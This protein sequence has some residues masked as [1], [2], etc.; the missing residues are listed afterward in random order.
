L[1]V[2]KE[3]IAKLNYLGNRY[4]ARVM[5][6][7]SGWICERQEEKIDSERINRLFSLKTPDVYEKAYKL[8]KLLY[9]KTEYPGQQVTFDP[10]EL[11]KIFSKCWV[12]GESELLYLR[13]YLKKMGYIESANHISKITPD[14]FAYIENF[15]KNSESN[16]GFC[17]MWFDK[18][19]SS[20]WDEAIR[21]AIKMAGYD[22]MRIDKEPYNGGVVDEIIASIRRSKFVVADLTG[23]RDGVYFEAGFAKGLGI[24]VIF[25][26]RSDH[27]NTF[28]IHF[29]VQHFN[30]LL[31]EAH[32]CDKFKHNLSSRIES[33]LGR[34]NHVSD[35]L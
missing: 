8:L 22:A 34:G 16:I 1:L 14:G 10:E 35:K 25:T 33:T 3:I 7:I 26:C 18:E 17:A 4:N 6:N 9:A 24:E 30:F 29:D 19:L 31:W 5:S 23:H 2:N 20:V 12:Y 27:F 21:P 32:A 13:D 28:H 11:P 15:N